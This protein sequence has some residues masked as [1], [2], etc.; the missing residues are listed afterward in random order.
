M[1]TAEWKFVLV[2]SRDL[3]AIGD[4]YEARGKTLNVGLNKPGSCSFSYPFSGQLASSINPIKAGVIAYRKGST[5]QFEAIWSGYVTEVIDDATTESMQV[6][7]VGWFERLNKRLA[8]Q[9]VLYTSQY[10]KDIIFG[11]G[12]SS[13]AGTTTCP[14]G[15]LP[16]ANLRQ[17][18]PTG[19]QVIS[20]TLASGVV[21][22]PKKAVGEPVASGDTI[23]ERTTPS[24]TAI[25]S[26]VNGFVISIDG[27]KDAPKTY[28]P[29]G[30]YTLGVIGH[31]YSIPSGSYPSGVGAYPLPL[32]NGSSPN[33]ITWIEPGQYYSS[34]VGAGLSS[35]VTP[36]QKN[37]KIEQDQSF[38]EAITSITAQ[39]NG[40]DIDVHPISRKLNVY[41]KKGDDKSNIFF[42]FGWG[43]E[44]VK[45]FSKNIQTSE[46]A[47]NL[48]GRSNGISPVLVATD[49]N[50][51]SEYGL[52]EDVLNLNQT[53][54]S[55]DTLRYY[56]AAEYIFRSGPLVSYSITPYPYTINSSVPEPFVDY[57]IGDKVQFRAIKSPRINES[58]AFR[59]FGISISIDDDGN[60]TIGELQ[61]YYG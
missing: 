24:G 20:E 8:K 19:P 40:P 50:S 43:P 13:A 45:Q 38:G 30:T 23:F 33:T 3:S 14:S 26:T 4:L 25:K 5:G 57:N 37:F 9:Q 22:T 7:C 11:T 60:E 18:N 28:V 52:F 59:V 49:S 46:I 41:A 44:N 58:G 2:N 42:G 1:E 47:N 6:S 12:L 27:T 29:S 55:S 36:S 16:L 10:D 48:I 21:L 39:E 32:V 53:A 15:I 54:A 31:Y 34:G 17:I 56:T 61:I 35:S 51:L